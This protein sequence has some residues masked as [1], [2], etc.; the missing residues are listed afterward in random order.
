MPIYLTSPGIGLLDI[1][2]LQVQPWFIKCRGI[3]L[4]Q[5]IDKLKLK[6]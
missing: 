5:R 4:Q 3:F 1:D 2:L 6:N